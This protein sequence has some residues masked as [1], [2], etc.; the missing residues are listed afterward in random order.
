MFRSDT[1]NSI[2]L[3]NKVGTLKYFLNTK[4]KPGVLK[5][6][7][8]PFLMDFGFLKLELGNQIWKFM[9]SYFGKFSGQFSKIAN[10]LEFGFSNELKM[11]FS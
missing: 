1:N 7:I 5:L 6:W 10:F 11:E 2:F 9:C 3:T 8:S 4:S